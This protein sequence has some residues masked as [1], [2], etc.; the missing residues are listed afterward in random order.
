MSLEWS[1]D[2]GFLPGAT[3][4]LGFSQYT[5]LFQVARPE[6]LS[7]IEETLCLRGQEKVSFLPTACADS[8]E[9]IE[10]LS[11]VSA[12]TSKRQCRICLLTTETRKNPIIA[13]CRCCGTM[14]FVHSGCLVVS[15][16][17]ISAHSQIHC[18][19]TGSKYRPRRSHRRPNASF[20]GIT[21][22]EGPSSEYVFSHIAALLAL[23]CMPSK[24]QPVPIQLSRL[25]LPHIDFRDQVLNFLFMCLIGIMFF[26]GWV[27]VRYL[28]ISENRR[29][30]YRYSFKKISLGAGWM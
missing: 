28:K 22:G 3:A 17:N 11:S 19:S 27:A 16:A 9:D 12:G 2:R 4:L 25:H 13:P 24:N 8:C 14:Q 26:C 7:V 30:F 18:C 5:R 10:R 6:N 1:L 21:T 15:Y 20:A 23:C 29:R